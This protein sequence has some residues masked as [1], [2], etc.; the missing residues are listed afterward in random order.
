MIRAKVATTMATLGVVFGPTSGHAEWEQLALTSKSGRPL[1]SMVAKGDLVFADK[2]AGV[3]LHLQCSDG[4][5]FV[6]IFG[7]EPFFTQTPTSVRYWL[8][9]KLQPPE[10]WLVSDNHKSVGI[11]HDPAKALMRSLIGHQRLRLQIPVREQGLGFATFALGR[12]KEAV[13]N[14]AAKCGWSL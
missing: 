7:I 2:F 9:A 8:D 11:A 4:I 13:T 12:V 6:M 1:F 10:Q 3:D 5:T 14:V